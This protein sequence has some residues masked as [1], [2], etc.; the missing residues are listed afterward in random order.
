MSIKSLTLD[1]PGLVG[2]HPVYDCCSPTTCGARIAERQ[3][4]SRLPPPPPSRNR[5]RTPW[6]L[7]GFTPVFSLYWDDFSGREHRAWW[8]RRARDEVATGERA[9]VSRARFRGAGG[10]RCVRVPPGAPIVPVDPDRRRH[11]SGAGSCLRRPVVPPVID[12]RKPIG[13][14]NRRMRGYVPGSTPGGRYVR[15]ATFRH[16]RLAGGR[17]GGKWHRGELAVPDRRGGLQPGADA[18]IGS[19]GMTRVAPRSDR[20]PSYLEDRFLNRP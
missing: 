6:A 2:I 4:R 14:L 13:G 12:E 11:R 20:R 1:H 18:Q 8:A 7:G 3:V 9:S 19:D 10:E 16:G 5:A 17:H 15:L